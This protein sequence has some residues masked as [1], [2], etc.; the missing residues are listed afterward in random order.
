MARLLIIGAAT[1]TLATMSLPS[2]LA[3]RNN[4]QASPGLIFTKDVEGKARFKREEALES[5]LETARDE[6]IK[7]LQA[8]KRAFLW[9]PTTVF[10]R[11]NLLGDVAEPSGSDWSRFETS[12]KH[13][14]LVKETP[15]NEENFPYTYIVKLHLKV[16]SQDF[17]RMQELDQPVREQARHTMVE[18]RQLWLGK[19]LLGVVVLLTA[20]SGYIRLEDATKGYYTGWLRLGLAGVGAAVAV[21]LLLL[22]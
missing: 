10:V 14:V 1:V 22:A 3:E 9:E 6:I 17:A 8:Q 16:T 7:F 15:T 18:Q 12:D 19:I 13:T 11:D 5:A 2:A 21:G 4:K 20:V